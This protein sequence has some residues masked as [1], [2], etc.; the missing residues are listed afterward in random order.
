MPQR[1]PKGQLFGENHFVALR[2]RRWA[3]R[4]TLAPAVDRPES[5][6]RARPSHLAASPAR[7]PPR[8]DLEWLAAR[9]DALYAHDALG[10]LV[11][12]RPPVTEGRVPRFVFARTRLGCAWRFA[13]D[14]PDDVVRALAR[15]A[16]LEAP[17]SLYPGE[18][19]A[20]PERLEP[21]RRVLEAAAPITGTWRGPAYRFDTT[22][23][24]RRRLE[25]AAVGAVVVRATSDPTFEECVEAWA[26]LAPADALREALP[27]AVS[28]HE[29]RIVSLCRTARR[30]PGGCAH[31]RID[32]LASA[33]G[34]GHAPRAVAAWALATSE[35]GCWP[36]YATAWTNRASISVARKLGL[37]VFCDGWSFT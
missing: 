14:Q 5:K 25:A 23:E 6:K 9:L 37:T 19:P 34:H 33:R 18:R 8:T 21:M 10:R 29:R 22:A 30:V 12:R 24:A 36:V 2:R 13:A 16:A 15:L 17:V 7:R 20:P 1:L 11:A 27:L 32:T 35:A 4:D 28:I 3:G 31:A 26:G